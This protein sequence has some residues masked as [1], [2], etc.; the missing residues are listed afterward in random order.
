MAMTRITQIKKIGLYVGFF[1]LAM[2]FTSCSNDDDINDIVE[3]N[4][5]PPTGIIWIDEW[6]SLSGNILT[7]PNIKVGQD[8]W[9]AAVPAGEETSNNF[10]ALPVKVEHGTTTN[11]QLTF[12][13]TII[14]DIDNGHRVVLKLYADN[15]N[16]GIPGEWDS[17]DEPIRLT[18]NELLIKT[19]SLYPD[20]ST[21]NWFE[22][23]DS[24]KDGFL[25]IDEILRTYPNAFDFYD[26]DHLT[27]DEFYYM[28]FLSTNTNYYDDG[29]TEAEWKEAH[30]RM[31]Y[32]WTE[33]NFTDFDKNENKFLNYVEW[34]EIFEESGWFEYYDVNSNSRLTEEE[35]N[36]GY[37]SDWDLNNDGLIDVGEFNHYRIF[38]FGIGFQEPYW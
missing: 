37:F 29:I 35:L 26:K 2:G 25:N 13:E 6:Q 8:S 10:I 32:N 11:V 18:T 23:Y 15:R 5:G 17:S 22:Y 38:T 24:N 14:N 1:L 19:I 21:Y 12:K 20:F 16:G 31:F 9:V 3:E 36:K 34:Q 4:A 27:L 28:M 30:S 33:D 7:V